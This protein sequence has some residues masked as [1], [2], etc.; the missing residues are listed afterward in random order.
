MAG[1]GGPVEADE[2]YVGGKVKNMHAHRRKHMKGGRSTDH[3]T[4]VAGV[5]DRIT[6]RV[7]AR[8][9][10]GRV[11]EVADR[12]RLRVSSTGGGGVQDRSCQ[13]RTV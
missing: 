7:A 8:P 4:A 5:K 1:F 3:K 2:A 13:Q 6:G 11:S 12:S 10:L 9:V